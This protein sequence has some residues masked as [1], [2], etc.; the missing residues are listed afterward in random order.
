MVQQIGSDRALAVK[1]DAG[2]VEQMEMLV[3]KTV[4]RFGR[5]DI[6]I[7]NAA[8]LPMCDLAGTSEEQFDKAMQ[9]NVKGPYF[10]CQVRKWKIK[11]R[12]TS[13]IG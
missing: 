9:L 5:I 2:S 8:M 7:P 12:S 3:N 4:E 1:A 13:L 6:L 11:N 10:L